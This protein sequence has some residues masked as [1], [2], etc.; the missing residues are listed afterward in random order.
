MPTATS[1]AALGR[2]NGFTRCLDKVDV[3]DFEDYV[4]LTLQE[5]MK[6]LWNLYEVQGFANGKFGGINSVKVGENIAYSVSD[7]SVI[8]DD[9][10]VDGYE[11]FKRAAGPEAQRLENCSVS[12][13]QDSA[14]KG[15]SNNGAFYINIVIADYYDGD[16]NDPSNHIG[17]GF[18]TTSAPSDGIYENAPILADGGFYGVGGSTSCVILTHYYPGDLDPADGGLGWSEERVTL[19]GIE[20]IKCTQDYEED[21]GS[22]A[23][24]ITGLD[25]YTY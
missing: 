3:N 23:S 17:Y 15:S 16:I 10:N 5:A 2:G 8:R 7:G 20:F 22:H 25:F 11:P 14:V 24:G 1:F 4:V 13:L 18:A 6:V 19:G 21:Q 12:P 9:S